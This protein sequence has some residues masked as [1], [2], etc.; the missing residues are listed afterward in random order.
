VG[1]Y[2][3]K[4]NMKPKV[5]FLHNTI[6]DYRIPWFELMSKKVDLTLLLFRESDKILKTLNVKGLKI[7]FLSHFKL[8]NKYGISLPLVKELIFNRYDVIISNDLYFFETY[9]SFFISKLKRKPH[10]IWAETFEWPRRPL[11]KILNPLIRLVVRNSTCIAT[12]KKSKEFLEK[13]GA[14]KVFISPDVS[15]AEIKNLDKVKKEILPIIK[16]KQVILYLSRIVPYKGPDIL[17][18]AFSKIKTKNV[19]LY[20]AG[21]G[22]FKE[23][24]KKLIQELNLKNTYFEEKFIGPEK[25]GAL[26]KLSD[27][28]VLPSTFRDYDA[29]CWGLVLNEAA[30]I[31]K[32][33][34]STDATGG[35]H[36]VIKQGV[37]GYMVKHNDVNE[38][39]E[40]LDKILSNKRLKERMGEASK[41]IIRHE[42]TYEKMAQGCIDAIN[43]TIH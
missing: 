20:I 28:F 37:N 5:Y 19:L 32:P 2:F 30:S 4:Y 42:F 12:G 15:L 35:A 3:L 34:I 33:L 11:S 27:V 23:N 36:D 22:P 21:D 25:K 29:D 13:Q 18:K 1:D 14:K 39:A 10:I 8:F 17:I 40:A 38:L 24:V 26:F 16:D 9:I 41:K 43:S 6:K 31:G 7:K